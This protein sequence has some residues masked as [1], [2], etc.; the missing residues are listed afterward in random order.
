[1][2]AAAAAA[3]AATAGP[4]RD[5]LFIY[6][7]P[8]GRSEA[9]KTASYI[10]KLL[11]H[12]S[13][14]PGRLVQARDY[15]PGSAEVPGFLFV[16][17]EE[18]TPDVPDALL[19]DLA[20]RKAPIVWVNLHVEKLL[21]LNPERWGLTHMGL[22]FSG[23]F[24]VTYKDRTFVKEDPEFNMIRVDVP[25]KVW[26]AARLDDGAGRTWP[27]VLRSRNLW[28]VAD[29]PYS[30]AHEG[31]RFLVLADLL[32]DVFGL[33]HPPS[34]RAMLR[35]EDLT[36]EDDPAEMRRIANFLAG[37]KVPF[38]V[39][40]VPRFRDPKSQVEID[41]ADRPEFVEA[42]RHMT[43]K[44]GT[45][46]L[47]GVTHQHRGLS[48]DDYEFWDDVSGEP[49]AFDSPDWV[50]QRLSQGL[51]DCFRQEIYPLAWETPHYSASRNTYRVIAEFFDTFND[52][53]MAADISGAQV[54]SPY[55]FRDS[56]L[57]VTVIPENLGYVDLDNPDPDRLLRNAENM[58]VVRDGLASCFFH[59]FVPLRHLKRLVR[60][61]KRQGWEFVSL[62]DFGCNL[63]TESHWVTST[64]GAG[65]ITAVNQY[66]R[67]TTWSRTG[68]LVSR[69]LGASRQKGRVSRRVGL[70]S[71]GLYV[72]ETLDLRPGRPRAAGPEWMSGLY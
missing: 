3:T 66:V 16:V 6:D 62:R 30:Y 52:R 50:R 13:L 57:G 26:V 5:V 69:K 68:R 42:V 48:T 11:S 59:S 32:H 10:E 41:L 63:R 17:F 2:L 55:P 20:R 33:D 18:G 25:D 35:I 27:Y 34:R 31:G 51:R 64:G 65:S 40:L 38:Q 71:G 21:E 9:F 70:P 14:G 29:A 22:D 12:F 47:H 53:L 44:G 46:V 28:Y 58:T 54:L 15:R 4:E 37:E 60:G 56:E 67:E 8:A 19:R 24:R 7:G 23:K 1:M 49:L 45:V 72:L 61:M 43:A 36:P 39:A